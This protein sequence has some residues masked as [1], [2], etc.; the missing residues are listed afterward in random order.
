MNCAIIKTGSQSIVIGSKYY[1]GYIPP[2]ENK[3]VK[4]TRIQDNHNEFKYSDNIKKIN[5]YKDYYSIPDDLRFLINPGQ[6]F[7]EHVKRLVEYDKMDIFDGPLQYSFID[8]A[9]DKEL[10][11]TIL[12]IQRKNDFSYWK[13]YKVITIFTK[14]I[15]ESINYLHN[16]KICHLDIKPENIVINTYN[17]T[18]K[19][20]DFGFASLEPFDDYLNFIHGTPGYFPKYFPND[21]KEPWLPRIEALDTIK[22][23]GV[24]PM[25]KNYKLVY[26]IDSYCLGRVLYYLKYMYSDNVMYTC[27]NREKRDGEKLDKIINSLLENDPYK[28]ITINQCLEKCF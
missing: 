21:K 22:V 25:R 13:S 4:I 24:I 17:N 1:R 16:I 26:K 23:N 14:R 12:D 28:R 10:L 11:D 20:V 19:I 15:M 7:Y 5:N 18:F 27:F 6:D 9:G 3:L 8:N 2:I